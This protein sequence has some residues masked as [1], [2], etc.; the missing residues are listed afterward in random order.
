MVI[1]YKSR[2]DL[3]NDKTYY[4]KTYKNM[5]TGWYVKV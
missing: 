4:D 1:T 2:K 3:K 5:Y